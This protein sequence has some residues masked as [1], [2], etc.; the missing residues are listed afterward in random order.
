MPDQP[1]L[2]VIHEHEFEE[3]LA[4]LVPNLEQADE[5]TAAV[6]DMLSRLPRSGRPVS[7]DGSI[8][9]CPMFPVRGRQVTLYYTF[10]ERAVTLLSIVA[11]DD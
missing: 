11:F 6:E 4:A 10:D 1:R 8:W 7:R 2:E 9:E 3:Q 5:F